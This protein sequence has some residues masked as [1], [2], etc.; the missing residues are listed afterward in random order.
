M[1]RN[2]VIGKEGGLPWHLPEDLRFF[3]RTTMGHALLMGRATFQGL[4]RA[5]PGRR[6]YVLSRQ[7]GVVQ[8]VHFIRSVEEALA[9]D[10]PLLFV[11]GGAEIYRLMLPHCHEL[12]LTR[13]RD[14]AEGDTLMP[15]FEDLFVFHERLEEG[16][17]WVIEKHL[18]KAGAC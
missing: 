15:D 9:L 7:P 2:R 17:H 16:D 8:G 1:A 18:R 10:E 5:L 13:L 14:D 12:L 6:T 11:C 4:G 3:K